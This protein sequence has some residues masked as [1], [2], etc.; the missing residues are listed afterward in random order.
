MTPPGSTHSESESDN[1]YVPKTP[2]PRSPSRDDPNSSHGFFN[3]NPGPRFDLYDQKQIFYENQANSSTPSW[4]RYDYMRHG[5]QLSWDWH[6]P[7][8]EH[9]NMVLDPDAPIPEEW[10]CPDG[11]ADLDDSVFEDFL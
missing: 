6:N 5:R 2:S 8:T 7:R 3:P 9:W 11:H 4:I 10:Y 1:I